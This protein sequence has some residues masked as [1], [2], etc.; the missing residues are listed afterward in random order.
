V[1]QIQF[2]AGVSLIDSEG[3]ALGKLCVLDHAPHH[4]ETTQEA[5]LRSLNTP[6]HYSNSA[7]KFKVLNSLP[8]KRDQLECSYS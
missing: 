7:A 2:Y 8:L 3:Y 4:L 5:A 6:L 1:S